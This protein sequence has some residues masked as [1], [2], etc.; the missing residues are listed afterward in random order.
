MNTPVELYPYGIRYVDLEVDVC[1]LP[2]SVAKIVDEDKLW[3]A[4]EKGFI[5][6]KLAN[7][8]IEKAREIVDEF[9]SK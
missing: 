2:N 7:F 5:T 8:V 9:D 6:K 3:K 4:V 1:I